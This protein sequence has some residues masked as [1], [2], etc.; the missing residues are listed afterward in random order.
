M[1]IKLN[2]FHSLKIENS[3]N[4]QTKK[5]KKEVVDRDKVH[6]KPVQADFQYIIVQQEGR[7]RFDMVN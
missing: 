7:E 1:K 2:Q 5:K 6:I 3:Q 4:D